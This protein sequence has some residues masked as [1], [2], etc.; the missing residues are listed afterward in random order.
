MY[1]LLR[2]ALDRSQKAGIAT[3]TMR[4]KEY[5]TAVRAQESV[6]SPTSPAGRP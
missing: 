5:L 2:S 1:G 6:P 4:G 3:F